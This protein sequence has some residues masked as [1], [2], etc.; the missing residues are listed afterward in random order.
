MKKVSII[1]PVYNVAPFIKRCLDS[2]CFQTYN[3]IECILVDD[4]GQ[5]NSISIIKEYIDTYTGKIV[6]KLISHQKNSGQATARNTGLKA[7]TGYYVFFMDSDDAITTDCIETLIALAEK[8][9]DIDFV[10]ANTVT[11]N[12]G[13][14]MPYSFS[15]TPP[16]YCNSKHELMRL[17]LSSLTMTVWNRLIKRDF[18]IENGLFFPE[19]ILCEDMYWI[20]FLAKATN[21]AAFTTH[22]TYYYFRNI[23]SDA[24]S[25]TKESRFKHFQGQIVAANAFLKDLIQSN[26]IDIYQRQY[27]AGNLVATMGNLAIVNSLKQWIV[28]WKFIYKTSW[29]FRTKI[30]INRC[31]L[32]LAMTPPLCFFSYTK[33]YLWR[34]K[35]YIISNV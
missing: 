7:A 34:L 17:I 28:F 27:F 22:G 15:S 11:N 30:T 23:N 13:T 6:F 3:N 12:D 5:D 31:I 32:F 2:I 26:S 20:Y 19:G 1:I 24:N 29:T 25:K 4:C 35:H 16:E 9:P 21:S 10:Q 33:G 8:Y 14:L 18:I